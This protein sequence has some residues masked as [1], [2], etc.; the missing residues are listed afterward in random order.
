MT[1]READE[2][3]EVQTFSAPIFL[4]KS[5]SAQSFLLVFLCVIVP[6]AVQSLYQESAT[7]YLFFKN[8]IYKSLVFITG[9]LFSAS[10]S[11]V[12]KNL[13]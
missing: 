2:R 11:H 3:L 5:F 1:Q 4:L 9:K 12:N 6:F 8:N 13:I 7:F 10:T